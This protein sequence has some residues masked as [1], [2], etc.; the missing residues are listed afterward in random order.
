MHENI[1]TSTY[2]MQGHMQKTGREKQAEMPVTVAMKLH[3]VDVGA[4]RAHPIKKGTHHDVRTA[5]GQVKWHTI[6]TTLMNT[7]H[8]SN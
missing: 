7:L 5:A 6:R 4:S 3:D 8:D 1:H 2:Y